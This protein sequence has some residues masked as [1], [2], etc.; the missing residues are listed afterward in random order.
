MKK[1][2]TSHVLVFEMKW[3][4]KKKLIKSV[5]DI[6]LYNIYAVVGTKD[7]MSQE[8]SVSQKVRATT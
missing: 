5:A 2:F 8:L 7:A 1:C 3:K 6:R 4:S